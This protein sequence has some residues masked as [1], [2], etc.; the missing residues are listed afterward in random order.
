ML[1]VL[2]PL[3][4][5]WHDN[6]RRVLVHPNTTSTYK[7]HTEPY[8]MDG[9]AVAP[10]CW[11]VKEWGIPDPNS[12]AR[13][14]ALLDESTVYTLSSRRHAS[15]GDKCKPEASLQRCNEYV[16]SVKSWRN[17]G[18]NRSNAIHL[19]N[20]TWTRESIAGRQNSFVCPHG[21]YISGTLGGVY[22]F[23]WRRRK[24]WNGKGRDGKPWGNQSRKL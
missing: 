24:E 23:G 19:M 8:V 20:N 16:K 9:E 11:N 7:D 14:A 6:L 17:Q 2:T 12:L 1:S 4:E 10:I 3:N 5:I 15:K 13:L 18:F 21:I 22:T